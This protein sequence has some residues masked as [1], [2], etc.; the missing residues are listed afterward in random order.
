MKLSRMLLTALGSSGSAPLSLPTQDLLYMFNAGQD[1]YSDT[2][3][4]TPATDGGAVSGW[5]DQGSGANHVTQGG[6]ST[7]KPTYRASVSAFNNKPAIETDGGDYLQATLA[8]PIL[9][10]RTNYVQY[11][12]FRYSTAS[13]DRTLIS[14][15]SA[16]S[17][18]PFVNYLV[19]GG[20]Q[21]AFH[22][23]DDGTFNTNLLSRS[24]NNNDNVAKLGAFRRTAAA[25]WETQLQTWQEKT[26]TTAAITT[27]TTNRLTIGARGRTTID[28]Q[29]SG[30]IAFIA[31]YSSQTNHDAIVAELQR[32]FGICNTYYSGVQKYFFTVGDS[33][34]AGWNDGIKAPC[35]GFGF[36]SF[37]GENLE[38]ATGLKWRELR[39]RGQHDGYT[40]ASIK[41]NVNGD[42]DTDLAAIPS[43]LVPECTFLNTGANDFPS[44]PTELNY[45]TNMLYI[46]DAINTKFPGKPIYIDNA[47]RRTY[48]TQADTAASRN[49]AIIA[50]RPGV[51]FAGLDERDWMENGDDGATYTSDGTHLNHAGN[52]QKAILLQ[53]LLGY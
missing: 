7:L 24:T 1:V 49:A 11:I 8:A 9:G 36:Q 17:A 35:G 46:I 31:A 3:L 10:N 42:I 22:V 27:T 25:A 26:D 21:R 44:M 32:Y 19:N 50:L 45:Q 34:T 14:E 16:A 13:G 2:G 20:Q 5:K 40:T 4:T 28:Q 38:T 33:K 47:W 23:D 52:I 29:F 12:V 39:P 53:A 48:G 37:L 51:A 41:D 15:G 6:A 18:T 43:G 30:Q